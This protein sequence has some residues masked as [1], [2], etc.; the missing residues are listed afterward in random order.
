MARFKLT[1]PH[2]IN[3]N[4]LEIDTEV[5]DG[6]PFPITAPSISMVAVDEEGTV[7]VEERAKSYG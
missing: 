6:T 5:G 4:Y 7:A 2:Y 3:G 1:A